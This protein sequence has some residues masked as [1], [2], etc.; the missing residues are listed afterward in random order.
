MMKTLCLADAA[1]FVVG[2]IEHQR[3]VNGHI[4]APCPA[5]STGELV[6]HRRA[7]RVQA[8]CSAGC[9]AWHIAQALGVPPP[10]VQEDE[11]TVEEWLDESGL[12]A[13][14]QADP[15]ETIRPVF[16][17]IG[18]L[19][20][21]AQTP[22]LRRVAA[23]IDR[24][25]AEVRKAYGASQRPASKPAVRPKVAGPENRPVIEIDPDAMPRV[26]EESVAALAGDE[27]VYQRGGRLVHVTREQGPAATDHGGQLRRTWLRRPPGSPM[28]VDATEAWLRLRLAA[29]RAWRKYDARAGGLVAALPPGWAAQMVTA[30][31]QW[32]ARPLELVVEVPTLRPDGSVLDTP[33]YD[34]STGL[35][36]DPGEVVYPTVPGNPTREEAVRALDVLAEPFAE[37]P[38]VKDS[39][40]MVVVAALL[41]VLARSAILG[42]VPL[43]AFTAPT[44]GTGKSKI[45]DAIANIATGRD[46]P[47]MPQSDGNDAEERKR[48]LAV[49]IE[50]HPL[51]VIDNC[52]DG[53]PLGSPSLDLALTGT[54][55]QD[56]LLGSSETVKAPLA[57]VWM[58]TGNNLQYGGD[59]PRRVVQCRLDAG[60]E[61]PEERTGF[62][63]ADIEGWCRQERP[64]IVVSALTLLRAYHV[65]GRPRAGL[66][67]FGSFEPWSDLVREA[68]VWADG[69]DPLAGR[70]DVVRSADPVRQALAAL[71]V[72]WHAVFKSLWRT[73]RDLLLEAVAEPKTAE[74]AALKE[75]LSALAPKWDGNTASSPVAQSVGQ[76]L[77]S[78][79]NIVLGGLRLEHQDDRNGALWRVALVGG[80][81]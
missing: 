44:A 25:L 30:L 14:Y 3:A 27:Q 10:P 29:L 11:L 20:R 12:L 81:A 76:R 50:G 75:A 52:K 71:F 65:A 55:F 43:F 57:A 54:I 5:C 8:E 62:E 38:G 48:L 60:V 35:L 59:L 47:R 28:I 39:D 1:G 32:P 7:D 42:N 16:G 18:R 61:H 36:Y 74:R 13:K 26:I 78:K 58:A 37:F 22:A 67:T 24:P 69:A 2:L 17:A 73:I 49:C 9:G 4:E 56:R 40:R 23:R 80:T 19:P 63:H 34:Y 79:K 46:A 33:G 41:T 53:V 6:V 66:S 68:I 70:R 31:G 51:V 21:L 45:V 64:R 15:T 77:R 72:A